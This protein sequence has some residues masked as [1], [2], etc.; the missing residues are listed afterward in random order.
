VADGGT[1]TTA[2]R[3]S[4][5]EAVINPLAGSTGPTALAEMQDLLSGF[6]FKANVQAAPPGELSKVLRDAVDRGPDLLIVLA[7]DGTARAAC[8]LA[9]AE[10]PL[11]A[12][13]PGGTMNI[14]PRALY[15]DR[16][17][18]T[19]LTD[20]LTLG[21]VRDIS[22]GEIEGRRFYVGAMLGWPALLARVREAAREHHIKLALHRTNIAWRRA[23]T[24]NVHFS[25]D[26]GPPQRAEALALLCPMV[27][28]RMKDETALE[29][30][31][32][33]AHGLRDVVR[34][35][36][37]AMAGDVLGDW[38]EDPAVTLGACREA[39]AWARGDL[40][41]YLDGEP[42]RLATHVRIAFQPKAFRALAPATEEP[43]TI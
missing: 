4:H 8:E 3:L 2:V 16:D 27:S 25:L 34:L 9:G 21:V 13:L 41:A 15:G 17:W 19:A 5:V 18:K 38:R 6:G 42:V 23:F 36:I 32:L 39:R 11:V 10:G 28:K 24:G 31:A 14:L 35:G 40:P 26:D 30:A 33:N 22:G 43:A 29:A 20:S 12:P 1:Q 7:G 37:R